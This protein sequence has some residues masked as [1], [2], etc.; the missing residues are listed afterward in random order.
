M[1]DFV[2]RFFHELTM[3]EE[4]RI[5]D[6]LSKSIDM[7]DLERRQRELMRKGIL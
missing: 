5:D 4:Q 7:H 1:I 2:K 3:T 6:Y